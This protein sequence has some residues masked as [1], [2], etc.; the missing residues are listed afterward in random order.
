[1]RKDIFKDTFERAI[2]SSQQ[3][4]VLFVEEKNNDRSVLTIK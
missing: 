3:E 2:N 4:L 1:M